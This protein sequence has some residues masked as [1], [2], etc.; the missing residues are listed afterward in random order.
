MTDVRLA[1]Q[2]RTLLIMVPGMGIKAADFDAEG[3]TGAAKHRWPVTTAY[4]DPGPNSYLDGSTEA[5]LLDGI[6]QA[7]DAAKTDRVWLAGI[8]LGCQAILRCVRARPDLASGLILLTPY[9][10]STGLVAQVAHAGGLRRWASTARQDDQESVLLTW[11]ANTPLAALPR[12]FLGH[13]LAD[14]FAMT[15]TMLADLLPAEQVVTVA[16]R[17]DWAS[18]RALWDKILDKN[19]PWAIA[20]S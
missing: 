11:L 4:V 14:R 17:H 2:A 13:A 16:G 9:L 15:A 6:A 3:I 5:R 7:R 12:I 1:P 19:P 10:A 18:W 8:S 20:T